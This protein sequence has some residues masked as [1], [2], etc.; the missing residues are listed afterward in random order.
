MEFRFIPY[1]DVTQYEVKSMREMM[2][3]YRQL[4]KR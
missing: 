2:Y 1:F 4:S 3:M